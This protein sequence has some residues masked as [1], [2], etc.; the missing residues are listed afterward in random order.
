VSGRDALRLSGPAILAH[1][2]DGTVLD[3][4]G[5]PV[6]GVTRTLRDLADAG[7]LIVPVTGRPL[8]GALEA[9][10]ALDVQAAAC[11]AYH[12]ALVVDL[13]SGTW[14]RHLTL[15]AGL[16]ADLAR[17]GQAAGLDLSLYVGDE[18]VDLRPGWTPSVDAFAERAAAA[19]VTRVVLTGDPRWVTPALPQLADARRAGLRIEHV[20]AGVVAVLPGRADKGDGLRLVAA[21]TGVPLSR[22]VACGDDLNDITLLLTAGRALAVGD[23]H[24]AVRAAAEVTAAREE[25]P[26]VLLHLFRRLG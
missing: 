8:R 17:A 25:L 23:P 5:R 9:T 26:A 19:G 24:P 6:P 7:V 10:A 20:R 15:P 22:V 11:V 16:V 12:G 1:D 2:I 14:L 4:Y 18:R 13:L 21:H 3:T